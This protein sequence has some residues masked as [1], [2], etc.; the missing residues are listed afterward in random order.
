LGKGQGEKRGDPRLGL[1]WNILS[2]YAMGVGLEEN[3]FFS[4]RG[5]MGGSEVR[6]GWKRPGK[7]LADQK[8]GQEEALGTISGL[9]LCEGVG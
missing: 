5:K 9:L 3:L 1:F 8:W 4:C 6:T 2:T 7:K